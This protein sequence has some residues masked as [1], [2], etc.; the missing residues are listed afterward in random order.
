MYN[1][2]LGMCMLGLM[3][4]CSSKLDLPEVYAVSEMKKVMKEGDDLSIHISWDTIERKRLYGVAPL[5]RLAGEVTVINGEMF[6]S[7]VDEEGKPLVTADW[8]AQSPF[9][10]YAMV[11][12][13]VVVDLEESIL[14]EYSLQTIIE[15]EAQKL[16][17]D[18]TQAFPF[19]VKGSFDTIVYHIMAK[20]KDQVAHNPELHKKAKVR[21]ELENVSGELIG[22]YSQHHEGVFTHKGSYIHTHFVDA[23]KK[24]AGHLEHVISKAEI[25]LMLP[26]YK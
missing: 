18:V 22:F 20:P 2:I 9:A 10:V 4:S 14:D 17:I 21:F 19:W 13:W 11:E 23:T 3:M 8:S 12:N 6:A 5:G 26:V 7:T 1:R 24:H 15:S 25:K 16:G